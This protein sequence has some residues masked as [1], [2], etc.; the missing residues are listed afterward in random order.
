MKW[1]LEWG[2]EN[3]VWVDTYKPCQRLQIVRCRTSVSRLRQVPSGELGLPVVCF[4]PLFW[5]RD[6]SLSRSIANPSSPGVPSLLN[7]SCKSNGDKPNAGRWLTYT[8]KIET[9][10]L[11]KE[12]QQVCHHHSRPRDVLTAASEAYLNL[13]TSQSD[14]KFLLTQFWKQAEN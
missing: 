4:V 5:S 2:R 12:D 7:A 9:R 1:R 8:A 10:L 14:L 11:F 6:K 3:N 13:S